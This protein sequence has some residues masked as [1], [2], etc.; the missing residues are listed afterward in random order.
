MSELVHLDVIPPELCTSAEVERILG[1]KNFMS[2]RTRKRFAGLR[3]A[4]V[5]HKR[6]EVYVFNR[7]EVE[8]CRYKPCPEGYIN[9]REAAQIM[10][11]TTLNGTAEKWLLQQGVPRKKIQARHSYWAWKRSAV[12]AVADRYWEKLDPQEWL[13]TAQAADILGMSNANVHRFAGKGR[14]IK[15]NVRTKAFFSRESVEQF[16][17]SRRSD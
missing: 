14:I 17:E 15:R 13:P 11:L 6:H 7:A 16:K 8:A 1:I 9:S 12:E 3:Y 4:R 5:Y 10:G 2:T